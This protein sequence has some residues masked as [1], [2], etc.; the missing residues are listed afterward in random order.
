MNQACH[1][2]KPGVEQQWPRGCSSMEKEGPREMEVEEAETSFLM[3]AS[4]Q[5]R[6][7]LT[8]G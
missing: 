2:S 4:A 6:K 1:K 7:K 5:S 3:Y 8:L